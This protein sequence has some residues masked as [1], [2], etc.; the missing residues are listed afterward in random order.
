[1]LV[2]AHIWNLPSSHLKTWTVCLKLQNETFASPPS[3]LSYQ[4][5]NQHSLNCS[6]YGRGDLGLILNAGQTKVLKVRFILCK[7]RKIL[8]LISEF[9]TNIEAF[10]HSKKSPQAS[11]SFN[12]TP[13]RKKFSTKPL[14]L[15]ELP[16]H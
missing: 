2:F 15:K 14:P 16:W 11:F 3:L 9:T 1:M 5:C 7:R 13:T 10:K 8:K 6:I 4:Y 12:D